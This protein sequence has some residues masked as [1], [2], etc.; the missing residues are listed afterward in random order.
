MKEQVDYSK[1]FVY[2]VSHIHCGEFDLGG[3]LYHPRYFHLYEQAREH[4]LIKHD[5]PYTSLIAENKHL[6]L[7]ESR[8]KFII[9]IFYG[10]KYTV[11]L[12][13]TNIKKASMVMH[14]DIFDV[15]TKKLVNKA[16]TKHAYVERI[17][18]KYKV[19]EMPKQLFN[20]MQLYRQ[21]VEVI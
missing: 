14:Y 17:G 2:N 21:D 18:D 9:P 5:V 11:Y 16:W 6:P 7:S 13:I 8:Q 20:V 15:D 12:W 3:V 10:K 4:L 19:T 1:C